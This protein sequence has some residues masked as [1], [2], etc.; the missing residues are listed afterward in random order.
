MW[1]IIDSCGIGCC[2][3]TYCIMTFVST[4]VIKVSILP[5]GK[6]SYINSGLCIIIYLLF[7][8]LAGLSHLRCMI[9]D[10][11]AIPKNSVLVSSED[12]Q[13]NNGTICL[14]CK[15]SKSSRTHHCSICERCILKM[16]HHC[17]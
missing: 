6:E 3:A 10:P 17:P 5:L 15:C 2:V 11:G 9:T 7:L 12:G 4:L 8:I 16:D 13:K 14:R 1:F